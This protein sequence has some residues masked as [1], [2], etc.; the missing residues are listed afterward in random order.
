MKKRRRGES[1]DVVMF[2]EIPKDKSE[3]C[4]CPAC[5]K[6][7][8][9]WEA[10]KKEADAKIRASFTNWNLELKKLVQEEK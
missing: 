9:F 2:S 1:E 4:S 5:I 6:A 7:M 10:W 3:P 8:D